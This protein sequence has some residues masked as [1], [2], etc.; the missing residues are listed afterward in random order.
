MQMKRPFILLFLLGVHCFTLSAQENIIP[1]DSFVVSGLVEAPVVFHFSDLKDYK[2]V[3]LG[4]MEIANHKGE[5]KRVYK[6][7]KGVTLTDM[8]AKVKITSPDARSLNQYYLVA[9]GSDGFAA[10][11]SWNELFNNEGAASFY[12]VTEADGESLQHRQE[13]MLLIAAK[14]VR[15]GRRF[16]KALVSIEI[17]R[18]Q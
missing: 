17:K 12:L 7:M 15:K 16:I 4:A 3:E 14:D 8:L 1:S 18:N 11:F 10:L 2:S 6:S 13:R 9:K 5:V